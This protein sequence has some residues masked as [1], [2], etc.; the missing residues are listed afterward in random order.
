[1]HRLPPP[2]AMSGPPSPWNEKPPMQS[3]NSAPPFTG[4]PSQPGNPAAEPSTSGAV[5][6]QQVEM[7]PDG[8]PIKKKN[9][10]GK[11]GSTVGNAAAGGLGF[12]AGAGECF[13]IS[14][15]CD[16]TQSCC[17]AWVY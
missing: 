1:M 5:Q 8:Q 4:Y 10:F 2:P 15:L 17:C 3:Y 13:S 7:G 11:I 16:A 6:Q 9:K 14:P 12:G